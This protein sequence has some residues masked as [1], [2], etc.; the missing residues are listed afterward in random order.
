MK[1]IS[2]I[3]KAL[4]AL[5]L[6]SLITM[7][8]VN[9]TH[10]VTSS[11]VINTNSATYLAGELPKY[12]RIYDEKSDP[13]VDAKNAL[14]LAQ[15]TNR[16]VLIEIGGNWCSW[17]H[18]MDAFLEKNPDIYQALHS[19]YVVLKVSVSDTNEN[20]TFMQS[21]PP[22]LGYPHMYVSTA[23]GKMILSKDTAELLDDNDY[24]RSQWLAFIT[25]W[26]KD[27]SL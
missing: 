17:C 1:F 27:S 4:L 16:Q 6:T 20:A 8:L 3:T 18:K 12:S 10:A 7:S 23:E 5:S 19:N 15:T 14:S 2:V 25:K 24:S 21:L 13:F 22:V 11:S 26:A 9:D